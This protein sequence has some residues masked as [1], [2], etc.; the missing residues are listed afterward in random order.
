VA[1]GG[2][3]RRTSTSP[4][5]AQ[6]QPSPRCSRDNDP[7]TSAAAALSAWPLTQP[8]MASRSCFAGSRSATSTEAWLKMFLWRTAERWVIIMTRKPRTRPRRT[9]R[10]TSPSMRRFS[11]NGFCGAT[12][13]G[14][15][16]HEMQRQPVLLIER[17][18]K[19]AHEA[20]A[21][22]GTHVGGGDDSRQI[23]LGND[24]GDARS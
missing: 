1:I 24:L 23:A 21:L 13:V 18:E 3:V 6:I 16:E 8:S 14:F 10:S 15:V 7:R 4:S 2:K 22:A 5:G 9:I 12:S 11:G 20:V 17:A 19:V